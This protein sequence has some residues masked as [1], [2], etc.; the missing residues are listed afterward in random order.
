MKI[1]KS[2][3]GWP[4]L[5]DDEDYEWA[6]QLTWYVQTKNGEPEA[7][8][9]TVGYAKES[10]LSHEI[11]EHQ[12]IK[13]LHE[14][15]HKDQNVLNYLRSNLRLAT[16][17]QNNANRG[18]NSNNTSGYKGVMFHKQTQKWKAFI[19]ID[20]KQIHLGLFHDPK[21]AALAYDRAAQ[22]LFG[23]FARPNFTGKGVP[24]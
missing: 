15:D 24:Q 7:V 2:T 9:R 14:V 13:V 23:E 8:R 6:S 3:N 20:R 4:I 18:L 10:Y 21:D 17:S 19:K 12:G 1:L 22:S 11:F 5:L 16:R